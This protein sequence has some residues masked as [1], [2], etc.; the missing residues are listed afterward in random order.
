MLCMYM[1]MCR[2][3]IWISSKPILYHP[4]SGG[5]PLRVFLVDTEGFSGVGLM[6]SRTY[7]AN[8][9]GMVYLMASAVVF[10]SM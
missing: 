5:K 9:F 7:E 10:N 2:G 8:L 1:C 4:P 3:G 6:T